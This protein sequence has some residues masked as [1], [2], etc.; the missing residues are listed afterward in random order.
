ML[1]NKL[2]YP[3]MDGSGKDVP[4]RILLKMYEGNVFQFPK[5]DKLSDSAKD[6]IRKMIMGDAKK[7]IRDKDILEHKWLVQEK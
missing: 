6:L 2:P 1:T 7:R 5:P 4:I 3:V